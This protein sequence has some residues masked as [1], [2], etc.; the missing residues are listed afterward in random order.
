MPTYD[1]YAPNDSPFGDALAAWASD[2]SALM[3]EDSSALDEF[4]SCADSLLAMPHYENDA[5]LTA[6]ARDCR[7]VANWQRA[8]RNDRERAERN[9]IH[10]SIIHASRA[11]GNA[12]SDHDRGHPAIEEAYGA[13]RQAQRVA[14]ADPTVRAIQAWAKE[15]YYNGADVIVEAFEA[16]EIVEAFVAGNSHAEALAAAAEYCDIREEARAACVAEGF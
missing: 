14:S 5:A 13:Y 1:R 11:Y 3:A 6:F 10:A 2:N 7:A 16:D 8:E 9:D 12:L 4:A 15:N